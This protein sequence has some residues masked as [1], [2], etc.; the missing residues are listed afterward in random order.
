MP[1]IIITLPH[2]CTV[3][4]PAH[5]K[6]SAKFNGIILKYRRCKL[7]IIG[8]FLRNLSMDIFRNMYTYRHI[9]IV[10]FQFINERPVKIN[11]V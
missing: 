8:I 10:M 1:D 6:A 11:R 9:R 7:H 4:S 5:S 2:F 3:K